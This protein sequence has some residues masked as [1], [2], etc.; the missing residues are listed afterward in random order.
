MEK[1]EI[2]EKL[3]SYNQR[4]IRLLQN[5]IEDINL[6]FDINQIFNTGKEIKNDAEFKRK[7]RKFY[8]MN[9]AGLTDSYFDYYFELLNSRRKNLNLSDI[10]NNTY[11]IPRRNGSPSLQ[12]SFA[13]KLLHT[14]ENTLPI[15][16]KNISV[17]FDLSQPLDRLDLRAYVGTPT[18]GRFSF[19]HII[20]K[21]MIR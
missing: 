9:S 13:T 8:V 16:D 20:S 11:W 14:I 17:I 10:L 4:I 19:E 18:W 6:Y 12:F 1:D 3:T 2:I 15:Y 5:R 21:N 7:Y